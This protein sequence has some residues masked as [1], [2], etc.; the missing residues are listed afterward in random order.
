M[1]YSTSHLMKYCLLIT[2]PGKHPQICPTPLHSCLYLLP[3]TAESNEQTNV[4]QTF[5]IHDHFEKL[6]TPCYVNFQNTVLNIKPNTRHNTRHNWILWAF[7]QLFSPSGK[8][9][10]KTATESSLVAEQVKDLVSS[11]QW[12]RSLLEHGLH[13]W[14]RN[15]HML[16]ASQTNK[17]KQKKLLPTE[18]F[19]LQNLY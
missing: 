4:S 11:L 5:K 7:R 2:L 15:L 9:Y 1:L 18:L 17:Q 6:K 10:S 16:Q 19:I 3:F 13:P 12:F 14:P 8:L